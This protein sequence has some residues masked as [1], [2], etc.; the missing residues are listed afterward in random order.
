MERQPPELETQ[1]PRVA[2]AAAAA[3]DFLARYDA[4]WFG[5]LVLVSPPAAA[6]EAASPSAPAQRRKEEEEEEEEEE[7]KLR[8]AE[9]EREVQ[10][11]PS[12]LLRHRRSRSDD[13]AA[14]P[15]EGLE[16]LRI[17]NSHRARLETILSGKDG[18]AA[19]QPLPLPERRRSEV[20]R[21]GRRRRRRGRSMSE[22]EFEEVKGLQDLGFTFSDAD[23]DAEL[24]SIVPGLRRRHSADEEEAR[25][26][27]TVSAASAQEEASRHSRQTSAAASAPR[28]PYLSEAWEDEE[29]EVKKMLQNCRIPPAGDGDDLK[30][31]IRLWA[32][33]VASA[34]R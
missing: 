6:V 4:F 2:M 27:I 7:E 18:L 3:E 15:F 25:K 23:V 1:P 10:R 19:P 14:V 8:L 11:A 17:P 34:V 16:P 29:E 12:G 9:S 13:A 20:R 22:L 33:T 5:R 30:E 32:H 24:A 31:H 28:R 21:P 26:A